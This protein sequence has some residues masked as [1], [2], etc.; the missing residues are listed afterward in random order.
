[1]THSLPRP[2]CGDDDTEVLVLP[3]G[4]RILAV[5]PSHLASTNVSIYVRT[6]SR[7]ESA[8]LNGISHVVEH[9]A[10]KG[11]ATRDCQQINL[12]AE[13]LGAEVNAH[14][15]K[16]HTA[17]HMRGLA[18]DALTFVRMLGDIVRHGSFPEAELER[19][20]QVILQE[21]LEDEDDALSTAF[22]LFDEA[23][24]GR[25]ALAQPVIGRRRNI[26][27]FSRDELTGYV[28]RQYTGSNLIV[29]V[30]G[31]VELQALARE[32][33]AVFGDMPAGTPNLVAPPTWVGGVKSR[34]QPGS[35]Q[36]HLVTGFP[37]PDRLDPLAATGVMAA[38]V[39][40]EGMSSPLLDRVRERLGLV[41][42]AGCS[43][44]Q[45]DLAGQFVLEASTTAEH[46][47]ACQDEIVALLQA[48]A[49]RVSETDLLRA[50]NQI[51]VRAVRQ[52]EG[53]QHRLESAALD[54][55]ALGRVRSGAEWLAAL[56]AVDADAVRDCTRRMLASPAAVA[57]TGKV[58]TGTRERTEERME[59]L[60]ST[61]TG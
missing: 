46:L 1:M 13:L 25:H 23:S 42:Y 2:A 53:A 52:R 59:R 8:R 60:R 20:R 9:M 35:S 21:F 26:E 41:Y 15:D 10:F 5:R 58:P 49:E 48:Q 45:S 47:E 57:I 16:D 43:T 61:V 31:P 18:R 29:A 56:E 22:K 38:A 39:L 30:S 7:H 34:R 51:A 33:E 37:L 40:G 55:F 44:D 4:V 12:E 19:E 32:V 6:G 3:N 14:T 28:A 50:R 27:R 36:T 11:T 24:F 17:Y 54:L